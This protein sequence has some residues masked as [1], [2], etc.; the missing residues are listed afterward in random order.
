MQTIDT[1]SLEKKMLIA[2][3]QIG[4]SSIFFQSVL[5]I[6]KHT[7]AGVMGMIVN[8]PIQINNEDLLTN[9]GLS[10]NEKAPNNKRDI[11]IGGPSDRESGFILYQDKK[12][13]DINLSSSVKMFQ[14][15]VMG[16]ST[17]KSEII[18][19]FCS[20]EASQIFEEINNNCWLISELKS[21]IL[22]DIEYSKRWKFSLETLGLKPEEIATGNN[23]NC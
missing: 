1:T 20:W 9:I 7:D 17:D 12:T 21:D 15:I 4:P 14:N 22:F 23:G 10:I 11:L 3:P 19:G 5:Y 2:T 18:I 6:Y 16:N 13:Q 8:H